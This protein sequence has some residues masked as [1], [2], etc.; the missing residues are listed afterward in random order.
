[1][2]KKT[3]ALA[4][5]LFLVF[6]IPTVYAADSASIAEYLKNRTQKLH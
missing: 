5:A 3:F 6:S 4:I 1:M 2:I